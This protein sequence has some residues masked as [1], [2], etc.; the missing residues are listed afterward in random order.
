VDHVLRQREVSAWA[1][2]DTKTMQRDIDQDKL[3]QASDRLR[4]LVSR[5][6]RTDD[7]ESS[8]CSWP[9]VIEELSQATTAPSP[10]TVYPIATVLPASPLL[11]YR[12]REL[13]IE[14]L[15]RC[16]RQLPVLSHG[17][18]SQHSILARQAGVTSTE[19]RLALDELVFLN[20]SAAHVS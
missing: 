3:Q 11:D 6:R 13:T 5:A 14:V 7:S 9:S 1:A 17:D 20:R 12:P 2:M 19:W 15:L 18:G 10:S 16:L 8:E 4:T